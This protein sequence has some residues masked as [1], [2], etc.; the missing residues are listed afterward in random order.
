MLEIATEK[1]PT[2]EIY[3]IV[4]KG[5]I[6]SVTSSDFKN[7]FSRL[8]S[9][10]YRFFILEAS[11]LR[12]ISSAGL[13]GLSEFLRH[14]NEI[15]GAAAFSSPSSEVRMLLDFFNISA[16]FPVFGTV[17]EAEEYVAG[18]M[19]S[20]GSRLDLERGALLSAEGS[21]S[22]RENHH[23]GFLPSRPEAPADQDSFQ[24]RQR[25]V[26]T[27]APTSSRTR[28]RQPSGS[29]SLSGHALADEDSVLIC[30]Q[31]GTTMRV[32]KSGRHM[33]PECS[34]EFFVKKDGSVSY[35][36]KF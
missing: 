33:C 21:V 12:T 11:R 1:N 24:I 13:A 26:Q 8:L 30:E 35:F 20:A 31:C 25:S 28:N 3:V 2:K 4:L 16:H 6:N 18:R 5:E 34:V 9:D 32:Y 23:G 17:Y 36:E 7:F 27:H 14:L 22:V 10:H 29:R 15:G 19:S